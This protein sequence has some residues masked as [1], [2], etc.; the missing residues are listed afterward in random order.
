MSGLP[1]RTQVAIVGAG[2]CGCL[3]AYRLALAGREVV[4]LEAGPRVVRRRAVNAYRE[5]PYRGISSP[6]P[7]HAL[8]PRPTLDDL[9]H[10]YLQSGPDLFMGLY[11]RRVGGST[12]HWLGTVLRMLEEDFRMRSLHGVG[13]DWP[14]SLADLEPYY[15]AAE[16]EL[17]VA[18]PPPAPMPPHPFSKVDL[19]VA[20]ACRELG[21]PFVALPQAR[22]SVRYQ[23]RPAC[24]GNASC[25]PICPVGA[26]YDASVHAELA[27]R[28][29]AG[30]FAETAVV[31]L[32]TGA[33]GRV[34]EL[35]YRQT[36]GRSGVLGA[37]LFV[38]AGHGIETP[39]LLLH[40]GL[41]N[42]SDAVGR[43]LMGGTAVLSWGLA[44]APVSPRQGP[45]ASMGLPGQRG[46]PHRAGHS[47]FLTAVASDGWPHGG[48]STLLKGLLARGTRGPSLREALTSHLARQVALVSTCEEL[49]EA[50]NRIVC[51]ARFPDALGVGR[52]RLS[53]RLGD[54]T[55][56]AL[57]VAQEI[58]AA[59]LSA[60]RAGEIGHQYPAADSAYLLGTTRMGT[61]PRSSV[62]NADLRCHDH[63]NLYLLGGSVYP[64]TGSA[65]PTLTAAALALRLAD[66]LAT[67]H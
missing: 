51:D 50:A 43:Y 47:G 61:N 12:W 34:R 24:C 39:R 52:P 60:M 67:A 1:A 6:Y 19:A 7:E 16:R 20:E 62:V 27:E 23:D 49:P 17:G 3:L 42:S 57:P 22:N 41:A 10:H 4:V 44:P 15:E 37:D 5:N 2:V 48:P 56:R 21:M 46:G 28:A 32:R 8:A 31:G 66:Y 14:L 30:I 29:G 45:Q 38:L 35:S 64:T 58:H 65:P 36:E 26:K 53:Y 63:P 55:R 59:V 40:S 9:Q 13:E 54:Y 11:E 18:G 33:D 25:V